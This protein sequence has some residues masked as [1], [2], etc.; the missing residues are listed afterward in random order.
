MAQTDE[1]DAKLLDPEDIVGEEE[2]E[3][4]VVSWSNEFWELL[5]LAAPAMIQLMGCDN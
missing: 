4:Y 3:P 5:K 1:L 2:E